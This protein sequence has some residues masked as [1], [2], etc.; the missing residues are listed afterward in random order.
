MTF[1]RK[2]AWA[3]LILFATV[4]VGTVVVTIVVKPWTLALFIG[5][6]LAVVVIV[7]AVET[8]MGE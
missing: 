4:I 3:I 5:M 2:I 8:V 1:L 6:P 7:W